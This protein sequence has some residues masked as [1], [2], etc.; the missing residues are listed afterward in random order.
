D[1]ELTLTVTGATTEARGG[2]TGQSVSTLDATLAGDSGA[3]AFFASDASGTEDQP[4]ALTIASSLTDTDGSETLSIEISG[5]PAGAS[6]SDR[7]SGGEGKGG[8]P[9]GGRV[10]DKHKADG[11]REAELTL[12]VTGRRTGR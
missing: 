6:L 10:G 7:K 2:D 1:A 8:G 3:D 4:I 5:V 11:D 12:E 9:R